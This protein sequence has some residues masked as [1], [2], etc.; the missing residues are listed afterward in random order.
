MNKWWRP[1]RRWWRDPA[2]K[3]DDI[4]DGPARGDFEQIIQ[5]RL[6]PVF[7]KAYTRALVALTEGDQFDDAYLRD[8]L[9]ALF[10]PVLTNAA[11]F[12]LGELE[13]EF[14]LGL[15]P[16]AVQDEARTWAK[17]GLDGGFFFYTVSRATEFERINW[18][19]R[20]ID[21]PEVKVEP[22]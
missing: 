9:I 7:E 13:G 16:D 11:I 19:L 20:L 22:Y 18:M 15:E 8:E 2:L 10:L 12:A 3:A 1:P 21:F 14:A 6:K 4:Y 17:Q 5:D